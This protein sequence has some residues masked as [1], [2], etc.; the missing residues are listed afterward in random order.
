MV[1]HIFP[2]P[3]FIT[4]VFRMSAGTIVTGEAGDLAGAAQIVGSV[5]DDT[6]RHTIGDDNSPVLG[7]VLPSIGMA[8]CGTRVTLVTRDITPSAQVIRTVAG[9]AVL[10][11][12]L[13]DL[14][15]MRRPARPAALV[16][17]RPVVTF[18]TRDLA[19]AAM[20]VRSVADD[21]GGHAFVSNE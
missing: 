12:I 18:V 9:G 5:A 19:R 4:P 10:L 16:S 17:A 1:L 11:S 14:F 8:S 6:T 21:T 13:P 20:I 2:V 3:G 15:A 7:F